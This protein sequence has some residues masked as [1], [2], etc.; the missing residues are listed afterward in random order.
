MECKSF[1]L[2][3]NIAVLV[4]EAGSVDEAEELT[5]SLLDHIHHKVVEPKSG[6]ASWVVGGGTVSRGSSL[7]VGENSVNGGED[8][9]HES[10]DEGGE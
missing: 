5:N 8:N 9:S 10:T 2:E 7:R 1:D 4:R 3:S 6:E